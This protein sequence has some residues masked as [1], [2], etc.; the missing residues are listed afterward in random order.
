MSRTYEEK[1]SAIHLLLGIPEDYATRRKLP[2]QEE[3]TDLQ[4]AGKDI[5]ERELYMD[6]QALQSWKAMCAAA[7]DE[8]IEL[9]PVSAYRSIE[10]QQ[11][12]FEKKLSSGQRIEEILRVNAA[13]GFSEHHT[14]RALDL[15]CPGAECLEE[16][17]EH[18]PAFAWLMQH[19]ADFSFYLSFPR[20]NPQGFLY[21]PWH[22]CYQGK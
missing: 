16:S 5:F 18:T 11:K 8:G 21:E 20:N 4:A 3:C 19:A 6:A 10:Y 14:G 12:L 9:Q 7:Q 2:I 22:W 13:P 1:I 17:F 15:T